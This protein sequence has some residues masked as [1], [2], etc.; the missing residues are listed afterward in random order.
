MKEKP[1]ERVFIVRANISSVVDDPQTRS[2]TSLTALLK[3]RLSQSTRVFKVREDKELW[4]KSKNWS[5]PNAL[6][7]LQEQDY[8][9]SGSHDC[10]KSLLSL[11]RHRA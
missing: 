2:F 3:V 7:E 9:L 8:K 10:H 6:Q 11:L 4:F 5:V 1:E